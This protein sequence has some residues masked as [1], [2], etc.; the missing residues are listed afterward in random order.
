MRISPAQRQS[1]VRATHQSFGEESS[2]C[3]FGSRAD[4]S[5][6]GG[7]VDLYVET[8]QSHP[9][10]VELLR[11]A[12]PESLEQTVGKSLRCAWVLSEIV[13]KGINYHYSPIGLTRA[14][15]LGKYELAFG[16]FRSRDYQGVPKGY[17]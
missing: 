12:T 17:L 11:K 5:R 16:L 15:I 13:S 10:M 3:L 4:D 9:L 2:V 14:E 1:I 8:S 6:R 7:D